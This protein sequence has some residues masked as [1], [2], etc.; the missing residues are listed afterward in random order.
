M[1]ST[2]AGQETTAVPDRVPR[3]PREPPQEDDFYEPSIEL[4]RKALEI[5]AKTQDHALEGYLL[6][7]RRVGALAPG[8]DRQAADLFAR[9]AATHRDASV[10]L[11]LATDLRYLATVARMGRGDLERRALLDSSEEIVEGAGE[12]MQALADIRLR[13]RPPRPG[14][15]RERGGVHR[16]RP[17]SSRQRW[18]MVPQAS[19]TARSCGSDSRRR[20][21]RQA[22]PVRGE[23]LG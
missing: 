2:T 17:R 10:R 1:R 22:L 5:N 21:E 14:A 3:E 6:L 23:V 9:A 18:A 16:L 11:L 12:L 8:R 20:L 15:G 13:P 4:C 7:E 19:W